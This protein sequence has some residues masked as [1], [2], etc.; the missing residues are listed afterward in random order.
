MFFANI[1]KTKTDKQS[2]TKF[3]QLTCKV[4]SL[5]ISP[6]GPVKAN[7][8]KC[9]NVYVYEVSLTFKIKKMSK[10]IGGKGKQNT[11]VLK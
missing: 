4:G 2:M 3:W 8:A 6:T 5:R 1:A 11:T 10:M 7:V 9:Q